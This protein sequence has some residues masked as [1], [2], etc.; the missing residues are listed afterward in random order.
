MDGGGDALMP[1]LLRWL[2]V[3][4]GLRECGSRH[5]PDGG[6]SSHKMKIH[7]NIHSASRGFIIFDHESMLDP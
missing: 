6:V 1:A 5:M 2:L 4:I 3:A 7:C